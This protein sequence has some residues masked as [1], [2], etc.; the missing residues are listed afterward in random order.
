MCAQQVV[1]QK[2]KKVGVNRAPAGQTGAQAG[3]EPALLTQAVVQR[4]RSTPHNLTPADVAILQ[5][6]IGNQAVQRLLRPAE[7][8]SRAH[9]QPPVARQPQRTQP[10]VRT[11]LHPTSLAAKPN[12]ILQ[13]SFMEEQRRDWKA[14]PTGAKAMGVVAS[15][16]NA[17]PGAMVGGY[18]GATGA[19]NSVMA[20]G[21][22]NPS[23]WRKAAAV[24]AGAL[25]GIGG[26]IGGAV[27]GALWGIA[28]PLWSG[29][30]RAG[31]GLGY[32]GGQAQKAPG[33]I[34]N[35]RGIYDGT[36][37][38]NAD[39]ATDLTNY[40][41]IGGTAL[42]GAS[43]FGMGLGSELAGQK[44]MVDQVNIGSGLSKNMQAV[45]GLGAG[46][47]ILG[48]GSALLD[49][50][51]G[52][53]QAR[54]KSNRTSERR[55]GGLNM[56]QGLASA[57]QSA[58]SSAANIAG[59]AGNAAAMA[60][61]SVAVGGAGIATGAIDMLRG[62]YGFYK[63]GQRRDALN[64]IANAPK[65]RVSE[66]S[67]E[68]RAETED[69]IRIRN[70]AKQAASTQQ[71]RRDT[72]ASNMAKGAVAVAGGILVVAAMTNPVGWALLGGAAI[73][74]GI[75]AFVK[76][77]NNKKR[78]KE[79]AIRELG[80]E[81]ERKAWKQK[82]AKVEKDTWYGTDARGQGMAAIGADPL[83]IKLAEKGFADV[84]H[85]YAD[86]ITRTAQF[87]YDN[88]V[89]GDNQQAKALVE[90]MGLKVNKDPSNPAKS[91]PTVAKIA[92]NLHD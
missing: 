35:A 28:N 81:Q 67:Q 55:L 89:Q 44:S 92:K 47:G 70:A 53:S 42:G 87:L 18:K 69:E 34:R 4:A 19:Y 51:H 27:G 16:L 36:T 17:I 79:V 37:N 13:R 2:Q 73:I 84:G 86:Y 75:A 71:N 50:G 85:F 91:G 46:A 23:R 31:R 29:V 56:M 80:I 38:Y 88:G 63:G 14:M 40:G 32:L 48:A 77:R 6:T 20:G 60:G 65:P 39:T 41:M 78:K 24:G 26:T 57:T 52:L 25:G 43:R 76:Y 58:S 82:K 5:R 8:N 66:E 72:G 74:G 30:K 83:D 33:A 59:L 61:A 7:A 22:A 1:E 10:K 49:A 12:H 3:V 68:E 21:G 54:D 15:P 90:G 45:G 9:I 64:K 11:H 62:G